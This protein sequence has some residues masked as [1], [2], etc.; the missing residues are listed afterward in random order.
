MR[1]TERLA[2][3]KVVGLGVREP[4]KSFSIY[5][6]LM[7]KKQAGEREPKAKD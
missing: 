4:C 2:V 6:L 1:A 3:R 7:S 5:E